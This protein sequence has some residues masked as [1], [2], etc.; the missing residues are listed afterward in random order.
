MNPSVLVSCLQQCCLV[1]VGFL[2]QGR[3][4]LLAHGYIHQRHLLGNFADIQGLKRDHEGMNQ[5]LGLTLDHLVDFH[6]AAK[7]LC[8]ID[9]GRVEDGCPR[10]WLLPTDSPEAPT[11]GPPRPWSSPCGNTKLAAAG[12]RPPQGHLHLPE[13]ARGLQCHETLAEAGVWTLKGTAEQQALG[14][15]DQL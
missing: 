12:P 5:R 6:Q 10:P 1:P 4:G 2:V 14:P 9:L 15:I 13:P 8:A 7:E 11:G 3:P